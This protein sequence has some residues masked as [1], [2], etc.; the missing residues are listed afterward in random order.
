MIKILD[1]YIFVEMLG[2]FFFGVATFTILFVAGGQL[3]VVTRMVTEDNTPISTALYYLANT[4]PAILVFTFPMAVLLAALLSFGRI[5]GESELVALK[6]GGVSF[7]RIAFPAIIMT[8]MVTLL[9][10]YINNDIAPNSTYIA[11]TILFDQL[12]KSDDLIRENLVLKGE[13]EDGVERI[14]FSRKLIPF[15]NRMEDATIQYYK[16]RKLIREVR[17]KDVYYNPEEHKWYLKV[18][19]IDDYSASPDSI[20]PEKTFTSISEEVYLPL[21]KSPIQI[22]KDRGR[23]PEEMNQKQLRRKLDE[24]YDKGFDSE[25]D[26]KRYREYEV[27]Y[28]QKIAIPFTCFVFGLFGIPLGVRPHRTSKA[29][30]LGL[31]IVFIFIYYV[32]MSTGMAMGRNGY[33]PALWAAWLPNIIFGSAGIILLIRVARQ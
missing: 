11:Q 14:I 8:L 16:D 9:S 17:A 18:A 24:M 30:G 33:M 32:L 4:L 21:D 12:T 22:A 6:A 26:L 31:S 19:R 1:R 27:Y 3:F 5:S 23:R 13:E 7:T 15:E 10:L 29:I 28:Y 25:N 2:P 20:D